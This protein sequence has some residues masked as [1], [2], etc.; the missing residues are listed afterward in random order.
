MPA[1]KLLSEC[2]I[3]SALPWVRWRPA[4]CLHNVRLGSLIS[5]PY[6]NRAALNLHGSLLRGAVARLADWYSNLSCS[7]RPIPRIRATLRPEDR[8][9]SEDQPDD[10]PR[11]QGLEASDDGIYSRHRP[12]ELP[13]HPRPADMHEQ[14][15]THGTK[16]EQG[17][18]DERPE[19]REPPGVGKRVESVL[20]LLWRPT[21]AREAWLLVVWRWPSGAQILRFPVPEE[22]VTYKICAMLE[23]W[24][25][26]PM[27][28]LA[29]RAL[30]L[31]ARK[32]Q[33][34]RRSKGWRK[35]VVEVERG[36]PDPPQARQDNRRRASSHGAPVM[37]SDRLL[38]TVLRAYQDA[39]NNEQT[40]KIFGTTT[41]LLSNLTNP[42]NLSILTSHF[43]T[44]RSIWQYPDG[45]RTCLRVISVYNT[46]A[47]HVRQNA[48]DNLEVPPGQPRIGSGV[49][50]EEW[51]RAVAKGADERSSRWQH[52][53]VLTGI[54]MGMESDEKRSLSR[55]L[56]STLE[57]AVVAAANLALQEPV[58]TGLLGRGAVVLA[59]SYA[60][61]LLSDHNKASLNGNALLP[62]AV[63]AMVGSEGFHNCDF[64][65]AITN[66]IK[67]S[68]NKWWQVDSPSVVRLRRT[69]SRPLTQNM[70]ALSRVL[71]FSVQHAAD[72]QPVLLALDQMLALTTALVQR[73]RACPL[74]TIDPAIEVAFFPPPVLSGPVTSL[75]QLFRRILYTVVAVLQPIIGRTLLDPR[76]RNDMVAPTVASKTL[77]ILRNMSFISSRQGASSFQVYTFTYMTALDIIT[78]FTDHCIAFLKNTQP[79][80]PQAS[81]LPSPLDQAL[82]LFYLNTAEHFPLSVPSPVAEALIVNP[83]SA[84]LAPTSWL[85]QPPTN[86]TTPPPSLT[87]ELFEAAHSAILAVMSCPQ[88]SGP[89]TVNLIPFYVDTLLSSFPARISPRQFR[90]A[91]KTVMQ[92]ASPPFP[93]S[94]SHPDLSEALLEMLR[95]RALQG[96]ASSLPLTPPASELA[97]APGDTQPPQP[98]P[99]QSEQSTLVLG[100][101]D[102][103]PYLPLPIVDE[104][105]TRAADAM[106]AIEDSTLREI[107][108]LPSLYLCHGCEK[109]ISSHSA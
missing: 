61:P 39:P 7:V 12:E 11:K 83:A 67:P 1:F 86:P 20:M 65:Q 36:E 4:S 84:L 95:H 79:P 40:D 22:S 21:Q 97:P 92:I 78:R 29:L 80:A 98:A 23:Q 71:V 48:L 60:F 75:W 52:C 54:L 44:A 69:E 74:S 99:P 59:L 89:L 43:L 73:W 25:Q 45:L 72:A 85:A 28:L 56:R 76:L 103:L 5:S 19:E 53:L 107:C 18:E 9:G 51:A 55:S 62:A 57:Q 106:N 3:C 38:T 14:R 42:L 91:F 94:A 37:S 26:V 8:D 108:S 41:H 16:V 17:I 105:L 66:D 24:W 32:G 58:H 6:C 82:T 15:Y 49:Q 34:L 96:G 64:I 31:W 50:C 101:I 102:A 77:H 35:V 13:R 104:W 46:A 33:G 63:E 2:S 109:R 81:A 90:L 30:P 100:L 93:I 10:A 68:Q 47:G 70:G 88:H 87:L 27:A